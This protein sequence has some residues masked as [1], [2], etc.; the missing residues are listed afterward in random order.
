MQCEL[1]YITPWHSNADVDSDFFIEVSDIKRFD[2]DNYLNIIFDHGKQGETPRLS[3]NFMDLYIFPKDIS[4]ICRTDF[5][6]ALSVW[7]FMY[8]YDKVFEKYFANAL[9]DSGRVLKLFSDYPQY[10]EEFRKNYT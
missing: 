9:L 3:M 7:G 4:W 10:Q 2:K 1:F 5:Y 6:L 8:P